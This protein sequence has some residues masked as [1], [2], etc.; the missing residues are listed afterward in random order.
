MRGSLLWSNDRDIMNLWMLQLRHEYPLVKKVSTNT[1]N[2]TVSRRTVYPL[3]IPFSKFFDNTELT[4]TPSPI[5]MPTAR[6]WTGIQR[7]IAVNAESPS[8]ATYILSTSPYKTCISMEMISGRDIFLKSFPMGSVPIS[9]SAAV[10]SPAF[11]LNSAVTVFSAIYSLSS[12]P[13]SNCPGG[14]PFLLR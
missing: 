11:L 8:F 12:P 3:F 7:E 2:I 9:F 4:P 14:A 1:D 6:Y 13:A 10:S 5:P